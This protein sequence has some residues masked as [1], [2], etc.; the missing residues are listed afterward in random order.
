MGG[1]EIT[2]VLIPRWVFSIVFVSFVNLQCVQHDWIKHLGIVI[3]AST[4][5]K[6]GD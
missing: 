6:Y 4:R 2:K 5:I 3:V 1:I